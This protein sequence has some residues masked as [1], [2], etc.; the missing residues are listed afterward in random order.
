MPITSLF[1]MEGLT[2]ALDF[3]LSQKVL[4]LLRDLD[5][6]ILG[7]GGRHYLVKDSRMKA[8]VFHRGYGT[9]LNQFPRHQG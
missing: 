9:G 6:D 3:P 1:P 5:E 7:M 4:E 8:D 2:L